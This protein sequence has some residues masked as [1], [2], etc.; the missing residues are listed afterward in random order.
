MQKR[1]LAFE[2][3]GHKRAYGFGE[4]QDDEEIDDDLQN[5]IGG[6]G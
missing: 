3:P 6:H 4:R 1:A 2:K 5:A